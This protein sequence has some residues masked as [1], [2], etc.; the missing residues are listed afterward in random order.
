VILLGLEDDW[1]SE[2]N[3][4]E[5]ECGEQ[6]TLADRSDEEALAVRELLRGIVRAPGA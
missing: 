5:C 4:F 1:C 2:R 3:V 6:L